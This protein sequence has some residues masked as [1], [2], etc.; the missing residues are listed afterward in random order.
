MCM[1]GT[2]TQPKNIVGLREEQRHQLVA[3]HGHCRYSRNKIWS[4][5]VTDYSL[6]ISLYLTEKSD[7]K[8]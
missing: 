6:N 4:P 8:T 7:S 3:A 2:K 5:E 1:R